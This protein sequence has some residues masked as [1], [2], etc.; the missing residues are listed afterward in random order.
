MLP[1]LLVMCIALESRFNLARSIDSRAAKQTVT[2]S[3]VIEASPRRQFLGLVQFSQLVSF[4]A[5]LT[6]DRFH[7]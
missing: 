5:S 6:S 7:G 2:L 4:L 1:A 3:G